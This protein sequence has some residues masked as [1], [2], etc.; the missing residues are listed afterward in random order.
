MSNENL[1]ILLIGD[2][3]C[4]PK[5]GL[6]NNN[7]DIE[8][9][10]T[11]KLQEKL[12]K[13]KIEK[14]IWGG[15]TTKQLTNFAISYYEKWQPD[16][17]IIHSG[18]NDVKKQFISNNL[19]YY[20]FKIFSLF[21][22]SKKKYKNDILYNPNLIKYR[23]VSKE[24]I[25]NFKDQILRIKSSFSKSKIIYIGIHSNKNINNQRPNTF[26]SIINFNKILKEEFRE[27]FIDDSLFSSEHD[28]TE[29]GYHLNKKG[30]NKLLEKILEIL[31]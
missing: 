5:F 16:I 6:P 4:L 2:S 1:K 29:D 10:Y 8:D 22:I 19:S 14:V 25:K 30:Q 7:I 20:V 13:H 24:E 17:V 28:Y 12:N 18:I 15:I 3:N 9:I 11:F 23:G 31:S 27:L 26:E 21:N